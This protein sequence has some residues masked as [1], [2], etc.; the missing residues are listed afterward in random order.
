VLA[1]TARRIL[2][3][4]ARRGL[5][6]EEDD[7]LARDDPLLA[8]LT[9]ASLR[10]RIATGPEAGRPWHRLGDGVGHVA[11][12]VEDAGR[13]LLE[14][15]LQLGGHPLRQALAEL[16]VGELPAGDA[17]Y[18]EARRRPRVGVQAREG[19]D[20]LAPGEVAAG[21]EDHDLVR[22]AHGREHDPRCAR[23]WGRQRG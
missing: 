10:S 3:T 11:R 1:G 12:P 21:S 4:L 15:G 9:A 5:G 19:R 6:D 17:E 13:E 14:G 18:R 7:S 20:Q 23:R 8:A 22:R 16:L 2:R